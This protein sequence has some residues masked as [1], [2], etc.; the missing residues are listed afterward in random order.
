MILSFAA[1]GSNVD[2]STLHI[3]QDY[4]LPVDLRRVA[5]MP[6]VQ[7]SYSIGTGLVEFDGRGGITAALAESWKID[8]SKRSLTFRLRDTKWSNGEAITASDVVS[9]FN[10]AKRAISKDVPSVFNSYV[11]IKAQSPREVNFELRENISA[12]K[13]LERLC[14]PM[15]GLARI[16]NGEMST[17]VSSGAYVLKRATE[18]ELELSKNPYWIHTHDRMFDTVIVRRPK[19][20][21]SVRTLKDDTWPMVINIPSFAL[22]KDVALLGP[23]PTS[24]RRHLDGLISLRFAGRSDVREFRTL[25]Q[26]LRTH[27]DFKALSEIVEF[28]VPADQVYPKGQQLYSSTPPKIEK[29]SMDDLKKS[30]KHKDVKILYAPDRIPNEMIKAV[31]RSLCRTLPFP[32]VF[33]ETKIQEI[34]NQRQAGVADLVLAGVGVDAINFDGALSYYFETEPNIIPS[35]DSMKGNFKRRMHEIRTSKV[36]DPIPAYRDLM[37]EVIETH[38]ILPLFH[39]ST[40]FLGKSSVDLSEAPLTIET[41]PYYTILKARK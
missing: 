33:I 17:N 35:D 20:P 28:A 6:D 27:G 16:E 12:M 39:V 41:L 32:C 4:R 40:T 15:Y 26:Y 18:T 37:K 19:A 22:K 24:W 3:Y 2:R 7:I 30:W 1:K 38:S 29:N 23:M 34:E 25:I 14:E 21:V 11:S 10:N 31:E 8:A 13:F 36:S 5:I 9:S